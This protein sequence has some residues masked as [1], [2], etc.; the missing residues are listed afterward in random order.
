MPAMV[1]PTAGGFGPLSITGPG[2]QPRDVSSAHAAASWSSLMLPTLAPVELFEKMQRG[3]ES[4]DSWTL[5]S[6]AGQ[7]R[8]RLAAVAGPA[9]DFVFAVEFVLIQSAD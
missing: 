5:T 1:P 9:T 8:L 6:A 3:C 4:N 2:W 7:L